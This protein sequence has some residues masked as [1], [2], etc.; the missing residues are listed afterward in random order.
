MRQEHPYSIVIWVNPG[1][2]ATA[3]AM[4]PG[5]TVY[6][7]HYITPGR[8][9]MLPLFSEIETENEASRNSVSVA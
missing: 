9:I 7:S 3:T 4:Y 8:I 6:N 2:M 1:D 5:A